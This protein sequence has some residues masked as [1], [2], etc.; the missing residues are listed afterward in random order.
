MNKFLA[1]SGLL[2]FIFVACG[3]DDFEPEPVVQKVFTYEFSGDYEIIDI[4]RYLGPTGEKVET[5]KEYLNEYW[6][7]LDT[8]SGNNLVIDFEKDSLYLKSDNLTT[9]FGIKQS[10][11]SIFVINTRGT[12]WFFGIL[13]DSG[14]SFSHYNS[15]YIRKF[16]E[17]PEKGIYGNF[18]FHRGS[19]Y[20]VGKYSDH[21]YEN[22]FK[23]PGDMTKEGDE[24]L[25]ANFIYQFKKQDK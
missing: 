18:I 2:I 20:G 17:R 1:L 14:N 5:S 12:T 15:Y 11:D 21:F 22:G 4:N 9:D 8:P 19:E 10:K 25:W 13:K 16:M 7:F 6:E 3:D 23:S 24:I